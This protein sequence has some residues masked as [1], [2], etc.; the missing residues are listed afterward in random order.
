MPDHVVSPDGCI[1]RLRFMIVSKYRIYCMY[2]HV[3]YMYSIVY[4]IVFSVSLVNSN[5]TVDQFGQTDELI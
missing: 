4:S 2:V 5:A 1:N 3:L